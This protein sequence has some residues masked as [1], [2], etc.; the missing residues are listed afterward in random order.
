MKVIP[1]ALEIQQNSIAI[2][3][4]HHIRH[5]IEQGPVAGLAVANPDFRVF[6]FGNFRLQFLVDNL[7]G[8]FP[9]LNAGRHFLEPGRDAGKL[10]V[11]N[12]FETI[13]VV[14]PGHTVD[15]FLEN[16]QG[17]AHEDAQ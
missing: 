10:A 6:A 17:V 7:Q 4:K 13:P 1:G 15:P 5:G 8:A 2:Q 12:L 16:V 11:V 14:A 9:G 3:V